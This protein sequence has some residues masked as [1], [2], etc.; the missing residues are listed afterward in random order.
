MSCAWVVVLFY[1]YA[2]GFHVLKTRTEVGVSL[3]NLVQIN[4]ANWYSDMMEQ[5]FS[6][7]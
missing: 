5:V 4:L 2:L 1:C 7:I 6:S 3:T